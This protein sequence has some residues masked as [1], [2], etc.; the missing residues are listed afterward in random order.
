MK[1]TDMRK[2]RSSMASIVDTATR[3]GLDSSLLYETVID[4]A[5]EGLLTA[6]CINAA[7]GIPVNEL[8][9]PGYFFRYLS[10]DAPRL[11]LRDCTE[12]GCTCRYR[13]YEDR[14]HEGVALDRN[15]MPLP[16]PSRRNTD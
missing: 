15:G 1:T 5:E 11:P 14:R 8:A 13:H 2:N 16:H 10:K 4:L 3:A 6:R 7:A 9:M 12:S